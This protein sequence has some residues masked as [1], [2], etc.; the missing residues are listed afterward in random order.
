[1]ASISEGVDDDDQSVTSAALG[2]ESSATSFTGGITA[3]RHVLLEL[4]DDEGDLQSLD[5]DSTIAYGSGDE[6]V[7][8]EGDG[9]ARL[10]AR[11]AA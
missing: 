1:M 10:P 4:D 2:I 7:D 5:G 6:T 3:P 9:D 11:R 8:Y